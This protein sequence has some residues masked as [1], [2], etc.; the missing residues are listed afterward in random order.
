MSKEH[1]LKILPEYFEPVRYGLKTFEIRKNDRDYHVGD[2]LIL[3]EFKDE[4]FTGNIVKAVVTYITDYAQQDNY[5]VMAI[6][7]ED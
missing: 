6:D 5:V 7:L 4:C 1:H 3:K 2:T